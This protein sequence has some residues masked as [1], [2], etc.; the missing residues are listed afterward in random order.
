MDE[1][2]NSAWS[3]DQA[4]AAYLEYMSHSGAYSALTIQ[5]R[6]YLLNSLAVYAREKGIESAGGISKKL[7]T[8]FFQS[9]NIANGTRVAQ[10]N[11]LISFCDFL[12]GEYVIEDNYAKL[13]KQPKNSRKVVETLTDTEL[14]K[15]YQCILANAKRNLVA[16]DLA[17]F[18]LLLFPGLRVSELIGLRMKHLHAE[19]QCIVVRRKGGNEQKLPI[20]QETL[21]HIEEMLEQRGALSPDDFLFVSLKTGQSL[22]RRGAEYIIN[23]YMEK[24]AGLVKR[25]LGPHL[26]RHTGATRMLKR[27]HDIR[28]VQEL[29]GHSN[30]ATTMIYTHT[31]FERQKSC[32][33][34][35]PNFGKN[36]A[37]G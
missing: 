34:D 16:R 19:E 2:I 31:D 14:H 23:S 17:M 3:W 11:E 29:L 8:L 32:G 21:S 22:S 12:E 27:G 13:L 37:D 15:V 20:Q 10:T 9:K 28:T 18:D 33:D 26:L 24:K 36:P 35:M 25:R 4:I 5:N 6:S 7:I 1:L 30:V